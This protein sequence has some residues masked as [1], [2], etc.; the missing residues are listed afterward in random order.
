MSNFS[1]GRWG[2]MAVAVAAV[3]AA[4][5]HA[6]TDTGTLTVTAT[7]ANQCAIGD[8]TLALG[9]ISLVNAGGTLGA[10]TGGGSA[11]VP[12]ACTNGTAATVTFGQ[13]QHS[14]GS[15]RRLRSTTAGSSNQY[16]EYVLRA[17]NSGGAVIGNSPIALTGADGTDRS[18]TVWGGPADTAANRAAK[19]A[20]DYADSVLMTITFT[21]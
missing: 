14:T 9:T 5:A 7:V 10:P 21:P 4:A 1:S 8:A 11:A 13:G 19:P 18:F 6:D 17:G 3:F 15:D 12:W 20:A 16:L 2:R